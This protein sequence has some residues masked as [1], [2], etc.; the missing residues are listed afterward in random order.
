MHLIKTLTATV[1]FAVS[2]T[3]SHAATIEAPKGNY[4]LDK[5]H[6]NVL[7]SVTHFGLSHYIG[8]FDNIE[9]TLT[10]DPANVQNSKIDITIDPA[11]VDTN[12]QSKPNTFN[13]EIAGA[14]FFNTN[15]YKTITFKSTA[16]KIT[17]KNTGKVTGDL[18]FHGVT[19][20]ITLDVTLNKALNPHPMT[21]KAALGF[22]ATGALKRSEFGVNA[23]IPMVSDE[24]K[25]VIETEFH[26]Q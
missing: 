3:F 11:S 16:I 21:K 5:N 13:Q 9:G 7:W 12:Y 10:L 26:Q 25:L 14:K 23:M 6:T 17:G 15:K 22:S 24:I 20:P 19:K 1:L 8:R 2:A 4:V 18:T